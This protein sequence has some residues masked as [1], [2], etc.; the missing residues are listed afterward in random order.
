MQIDPKSPPTLVVLLLAIT[1][2]AGSET[3]ADPQLTDDGGVFCSIDPDELIFRLRPD[4]IPALTDPPLVVPDAPGTE[5]LQDE[6]RVVALIV[7]GEPLA[8]PLKVLRWH[9]N[10]NLNRGGLQ[11]ALTYCPLT[12]TALVFDRSVVG[13]VE[14]GISGLLYRNNLVLFDRS[15]EPSFIPQM[16]R[17]P[18]CGPLAESGQILP[19]VAS[20]ELRW[21][22]W[23]AMHPNTLVVS[24]DTGF[25]RPYQL[26]PDPEY[27]RI[28]NPD[29]TVSIP[30]DPR[31]PPKERVL[32]IPQGFDGGPAFPFE[33]MKKSAR[34]AVSIFRGGRPGIV[35]WERDAE[36]A[37]AFFTEA[38]GAGA[39]FSAVSDGYVDSITG[40]RWRLDGL[41]VEGPLSGERLEPIPEAYVAFWFAWAD[42]Q[43]ETVIWTGGG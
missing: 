17:G 1:S 26:P 33:E 12:G 27:E 9:E 40:T 20:W 23:R 5:Y 13:G 2:C 14:L 41:A 3:I 11:L 31:R 39:S 29:V 15:E 4:G 35:F 38:A 22:A 37:L 6:D 43:P 19:M 42:F 18:Q 30:I 7:D 24:G 10:V 36:G 8:F 32:G 21:D 16:T 34:L 28:D 25:P